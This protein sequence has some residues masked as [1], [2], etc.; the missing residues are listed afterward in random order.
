MTFSMIKKEWRVVLEM[1]ADEYFV[2]IYNQASY[3]VM[4]NIRKKKDGK[5]IKW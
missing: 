1:G 3:G 5:D 4:C 2:F